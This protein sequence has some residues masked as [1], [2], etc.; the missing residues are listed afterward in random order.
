[1]KSF[2]LL[3]TLIVLSVIALS[4]YAQDDGKWRNFEV[5]LHCGLAIPS[6]DLSDWNDSLGA[7]TGLSVSLSG[8]YYFTNNICAGIYFDFNSFGM[9]GNWGLNYRLYNTGVYA[10]YALAGESNFEPYVKL[11]GGITW[12]KFPTWI[13]VDR[14]VLREQSYDPALGFGGYLGI[15]W[16]TAEFGGLYLEAGYQNI[17]SKDT[18]ADWHGQI[19]KMPGNI[20][21]LQIRSGVTVFFGGEE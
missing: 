19:Y 14:N 11:T 2:R 1:M 8:G 21:Y 3:L 18:E 9:E 16:Y 13:T 6:G 12:P 10:K 7:K 5:G 17:M 4:A 15:I 20:S